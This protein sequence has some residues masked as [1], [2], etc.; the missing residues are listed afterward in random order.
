MSSSDSSFWKEAINSEIDSILSNHIWELVDLPPGNKSL[1]SKWIFKRKIKADGTSDKYKAR[2]VVKGFKQKKGLDYFDTYSPVTRITSIRM[3]ITLAAVYDL[4]IHQMDVKTAF[5]NED[6][7]KEIYME[8]PEG[9]VVPGKKNKIT[10]SNEVKSTSGY[11]F[12]IGGGAISWKSSKQTCITRSIMES[13]FIAL[14]KASE[15]EEWLRNFL[16][17]ILYWPKLVALVCIHCDRQAAIDRSESM[18]YN[19]KSHHIKGR[20]NTVR[21][22]ISSVI[23]TIDYVKLKD[24]VS[25]PLTKGL[26]REGVERTSKEMGLRPRTSQHGGHSGVLVMMCYSHI[27][28]FTRKQRTN[29]EVHAMIQ[30]PGVKQRGDLDC[31]SSNMVISYLMHSREKVNPMIINND[32][33][34]SLYM[35]DVDAD[36]FRPILR[37]NVVD[38]SFEGLMNSSLSPPRCWIVDNDLIDYESDGDHPMNMEDDCVHMKAV[39]LDLKDAKEYCR[40][41]SQPVHFFYNG[42]NLYHDQ[43]FV[44]KKQ[45]KLLLDG[46]AVRQS[47]D[48]WSSYSIMV[49]QIDGS[50]VYYFLAFIACIRGYAHMRKLKSIVEDDPDLCVIS[51]RHISIT[52]AFSRVYSRA[53]HRLCMRHLTENIC[54]NQYCGEYL[55]L[56]FAMAKVRCDDH[57]TESL[58]SVLMDEREYPISYIFNSIA[59]K[60]GENFKERYAYVDGKKNIFVPCAEKILRDNKSAND[61]LYVTNP[62]GV[63]DQYMVFRNGVTTKVNLLERSCSCRKFDLVKMP[64]EHAMV[65]LRAKYGDGVGYGNSIYEYYSPIYKAASYL[66]AYSEAINVVPPEPEWNV[67]QELLDTKISPPLRSQTQKKES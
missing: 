29:Q 4:Q 10:G 22:L 41:G 55:Y 11:V 53:N 24:N 54:V 21:E 66:L 43:T 56:F 28:N 62:N 30:P 65:A 51:D 42:I 67:P 63:L 49:N 15:E 17:D 31:A 38:R 47:F 60:F 46:A 27:V 5:L 1:G 7:E 44:D 9:F 48:Y 64:C 14:D 37:I 32:A 61:S 36:G 39:L 23:I 58:N 13:E 20:H 25:D 40:T 52:N 35:M 3:L 59:K 8:Q 33:R 57:I 12:T 45:L 18:M 2:L 19:G 50:F 16:E 6:L 34:V 26:S